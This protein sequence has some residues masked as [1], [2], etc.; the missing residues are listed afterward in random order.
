[1]ELEIK[2]ILPKV[3]IGLPQIAVEQLDLVLNIRFGEHTEEIKG[4]SVT[5]G[6]KRGELKVSLTN[7]EV[8]LKNIKLRDAFQTVLETEVQEESGKEN[9]LG[10]TLVDKPGLSASI[11]EIGKTSE[12]VKYQ[13]YQVSTKGELNKPTWTFIAQIREQILQGMLQDTDLAT[14]DIKG[15]PCSLVATFCVTKPEDICI[16]DAQWLWSKNITKIGMAIIERGIVRKFLE[17]KLQQEPYLSQV[18][19]SYG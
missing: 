15:T 8:P 9:Q 18:E 3:P 14:I 13:R 17:E 7:G 19:L 6:L 2:P 11:K 12:K 4:G 1:M 16:T 10:V 5:F